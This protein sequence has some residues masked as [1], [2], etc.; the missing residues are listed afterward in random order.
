MRAALIFA[1]GLLCGALSP[2]YAR[3]SHYSTD[4]FVRMVEQGMTQALHKVIQPGVT[5]TTMDGTYEY[6]GTRIDGRHYHVDIDRLD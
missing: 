2:A 1:A 5:I 6:R 3:L 4:G